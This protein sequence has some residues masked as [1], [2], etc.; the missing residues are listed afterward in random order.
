MNSLQCTSLIHQIWLQFTSSFIKTRRHE[1]KDSSKFVELEV[2]V[3]TCSRRTFRGM[4]QTSFCFLAH[5][6]WE[7][8]HVLRH[9]STIC[10]SINSSFFSYLFIENKAK[11]KESFCQHR[12]ANSV[13]LCQAL[14]S[15]MLP[16]LQLFDDFS[17]A[18]RICHWNQVLYHQDKR[19]VA[20][21]HVEDCLRVKIL[22]AFIFG[23]Q[24]VFSS[25]FQKRTTSRHTASSSIK[26]KK[27]ADCRRIF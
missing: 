22:S 21:L 8:S 5:W 18:K 20:L 27:F 13:P 2:E 17:E 11:R 3:V 1:R 24:S 23:N 9:Q 26:L 12:A 4:C 16:L 7:F 10:W 25:R 6:K 19:I 14:A 15:S